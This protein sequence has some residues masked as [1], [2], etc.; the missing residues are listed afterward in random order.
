M[1]VFV[2]YDDSAWFSAVQVFIEPCSDSKQNRGRGGTVGFSV[3]HVHVL[4]PDYLLLFIPKKFGNLGGRKWEENSFQPF[5]ISAAPPV[6]EGEGGDLCS[7]FTQLRTLRR[8]FYT[9]P[10]LSPCVTPHCLKLH[11]LSYRC[12]PHPT[13]PSK[14]ENKICT[15]SAFHWGTAVDHTFCTNYF[16]CGLNSLFLLN[17]YLPVLIDTLACL[18]IAH[19]W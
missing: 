7:L 6:R 17:V 13:P 11:Q 2:S 19:Q 16:Y 12:P 14:K 18:G 4:H 8:T 9:F 15:C 5:C 1:N 3:H 10:W